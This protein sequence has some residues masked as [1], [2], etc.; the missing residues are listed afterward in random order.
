[1]ATEPPE[2]N[3][4]EVVEDTLIGTLAGEVTWPKVVAIAVVCAT[5]V[6]V[7]AICGYA[8]GWEA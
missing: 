8:P 5:L 3:D 6:A 7:C 2:E 1:M 4:A